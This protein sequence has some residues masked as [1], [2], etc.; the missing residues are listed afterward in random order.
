MAVINLAEGFP[1]QSVEDWLQ[2]I[3]E[4]HPGKY[5]QLRTATDHGY[6]LEPLY[7]T[8][9]ENHHPPDPG[10]APYTRGFAQSPPPWQ[11]RQ[12]VAHPDLSEANRIILQNLRQGVVAVSLVLDRATRRGLDPD[13]PQAITDGGAGG[14]PIASVDDLDLVLAGVPADIT[15]IT[16]HGGSAV[17]AQSALLIS[18]WRRRHCRLE[19]LK[20]S[21][22]AAPL[23]TWAALPTSRDEI[24]TAL[25]DLSILAQW[26]QIHAPN[27]RVAQASEHVYHNAGASDVDSLACVLAEIVTMLR[28]FH[29]DDHDLSL[30]L[31]QLDIE[32]ALS[33]DVFEGI[34]KIRALRMLLAKLAEVL[35][36]DISIKP[37]A[38]IAGLGLRSMTRYDPW[39]NLLRGTTATF[40]AAI[41]GTDMVSIPPFDSIATMYPDEL[42][43]RIA[44]NTATIL[45][46]EAHLTRVTDPAGGSGYIEN[47]TQLIA[48]QAWE[49]FQAIETEGGLIEAL[50]NGWLQARIEKSRVNRM[51]AVNSG[52]RAI[53]GINAFPDPNEQPLPPSTQ[54]ST[55]NWKPVADNRWQLTRARSKHVATSPPP[56]ASSSSMERVHFALRAAEHGATLAQIHRDLYPLSPASPPDIPTAKP[57]RAHRTAE[58]LETLRDAAKFH[59]PPIYLANIGS[60]ANHSP[61]ASFAQNLVGVGGWLTIH[62][63][64][65]VDAQETIQMFSASSA[66]VAIICGTDDDYAKHAHAFILGLK[67]AGA[68][69]IYLV[70]A[71]RGDTQAWTH[72]GLHGFLSLN[73]DIEAL[74]TELLRIHGQVT[75]ASGEQI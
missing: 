2:I 67:N 42:G 8:S 5:Q 35:D 50:C 65:T 26:C 34:A 24:D 64:P 27:I 13:D 20:G 71:P 12:A 38:I 33:P 4:N 30:G 74:L 59:L 19:T 68:H 57:L 75:H 69:Q 43:H 9:S 18:F 3:E 55:P 40:V 23:S 58:H 25:H 46:K 73:H 1:P 45:E 61:R 66:R 32:L 44:R 56:P 36:I 37:P 72:A 49:A 6:R 48:R 54:S 10:D 62:G 22:A 51:R 15:P 29:K 60:V 41:G 17:L 7:S 14:I 28:E 47:R 39:I 53:T 16:L 11:I 63:P 52:Q 31:G 21:L 70:G